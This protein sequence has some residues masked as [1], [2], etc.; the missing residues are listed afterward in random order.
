MTND[1]PT[2]TTP[3]HRDQPLVMDHTRRHLVVG[4]RELP[5]ILTA[6]YCPPDIPLPT[7]PMRRFGGGH[8]PA[9]PM[10]PSGRNHRPV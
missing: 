6:P 10:R 4:L 5:E 8:E 9:H 2:T 7:V 3:E 1:H